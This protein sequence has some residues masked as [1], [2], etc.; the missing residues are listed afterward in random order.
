LGC[1]CSDA[2]ESVRPGYCGMRFFDEKSWF[3]GGRWD[4]AWRA[5]A[6]GEDICA[7]MKGAG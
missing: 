6:F 4:R 2:W 3:Q 1:R 7:K 5:C